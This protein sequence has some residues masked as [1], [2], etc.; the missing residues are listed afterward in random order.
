M[1][2]KRTGK[3]KKQVRP[4]EVETLAPEQKTIVSMPKQPNKPRK[5]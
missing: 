4:P 3:K 5:K 2:D 1:S